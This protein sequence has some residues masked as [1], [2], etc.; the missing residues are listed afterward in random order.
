MIYAIPKAG[1]HVAPS[2]VTAREFTL[3]NTETRTLEEWIL[4]N[5]GR[6][7]IPSELK[8]KGVATVLCGAIDGALAQELS[9]LGIQVYPHFDD[10]VETLVERIKWDALD[11]VGIN[12]AQETHDSHG[13]GSGCCG[14]ASID[15]LLS[16]M[17][18]ALKEPLPFD[19]TILPKKPTS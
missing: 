4:P 6:D 5:Q 3:Y 7:F 15:S 9:R 19:P 2:L 18:H 14:G 13:C 12:V 10:E 1:F 16:Q 11:L 17:S 8:K